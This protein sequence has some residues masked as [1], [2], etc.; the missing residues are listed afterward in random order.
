MNYELKKR[1]VTAEKALEKLQLLC[2]R[3]EKCS[4]DAITLLRRWE[5][6]SDKIDG[7]I[8]SLKK[9]RY[10]DDSRYAAA[11]VRDKMNYSGWGERKIEQSLRMKGVEKAI[12]SEAI[13]STISKDS[14]RQKLNTLLNKKLKEIEKKET[15]K[16]KARAKLFNFAA[17]RGFDFDDIKSQIDRL[18]SI[19]D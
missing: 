16:F 2:S 3:A 5:V 1:V 12:I 9:D 19:E 13:H 7:I 14:M 6:D 17:S 11:Y 15:D 18:E 8:E 4:G 10:I